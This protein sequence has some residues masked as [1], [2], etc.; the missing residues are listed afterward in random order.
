MKLN[1]IDFAGI[2]LLLLTRLPSIAGL[3]FIAASVAFSILRII[4]L[5]K[6]NKQLTILSMIYASISI[7]LALSIVLHCSFSH[8]TSNIKAHLNARHLQ[9]CLEEYINN[10][11]DKAMI[12]ED[13]WYNE[14]SIYS[15][16]TPISFYVT[17]K[18]GTNFA[19]N[20]SLVGRKPSEIVNDTVLF[21]ETDSPKE[22]ISK[23][24]LSK[25]YKGKHLYLYDR[26]LHL[27]S[28]LNNNNFIK[29]NNFNEFD[30][31]DWGQD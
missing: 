8:V 20:K 4:G 28:S 1:N 26:N 14:I 3:F 13:S 19:I 24:A 11:K 17:A 23:E 2:L 25:E 12:F 15:R 27:S 5:K 22:L 9:T 7:S 21:I 18:K 16:S 6:A 31:L 10:R 29:I 30:R